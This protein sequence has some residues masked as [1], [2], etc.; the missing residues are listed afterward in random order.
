MKEGQSARSLCNFTE[1]ILGGGQGSEPGC[2][3]FV[4]RLSPQKQSK[5]KQQKNQQKKV[6]KRRAWG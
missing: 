5:K 4:P 1:C 3:D 6:G 2:I